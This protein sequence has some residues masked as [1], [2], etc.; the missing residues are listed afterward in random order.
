MIYSHRDHQRSYLKDKRLKQF[1]YSESKRLKQIILKLLKM[2][3]ES[4][5][6]SQDCTCGN[7]SCDGSNYK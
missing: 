5:K 2:S 3:K 6:N 1:V 7:T 4:N